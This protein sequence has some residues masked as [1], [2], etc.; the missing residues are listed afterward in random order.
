MNLLTRRR[1]GKDNANHRRDIFD[2]ANYY[3]YNDYYN[4]YSRIMINYE[5]GNEF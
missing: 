2:N 4:N 1:D 5:M 3:N